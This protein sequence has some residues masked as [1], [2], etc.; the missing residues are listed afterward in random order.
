MKRRYY[1]LVG[2]E[3]TGQCA[4]SPRP[5]QEK[6][7][8][9]QLVETILRDALVDQDIRVTGSMGLTE[10]DV[11][12]VV[13]AMREDAARLAANWQGQKT[14]LDRKLAELTILVDRVAPKQK[15]R[16]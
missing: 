13:L 2:I 11:D 1:V 12:R 14:T 3:V 6:E 9:A 4:S 15:E 16:P 7:S 5:V 10:D 8:T